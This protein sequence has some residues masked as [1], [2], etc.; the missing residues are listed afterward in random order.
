MTFSLYSLKLNTQALLEVLMIKVAHLNKNYG[1]IEA[2]KDFSLVINAREKLALLGPNGAGK[3]TVM[4]MLATLIRPSS[5]KITI[6]G[7]DVEKNSDAVR[8]LIGFLP[9]NPPIYPELRVREFLSFVAG[10]RSIS[11]KEEKQ[12]IDEVITNCNLESVYNRICGELSKGY[13][14]RLGIAQAIIHKPEILI[15]DEPTNGLDPTQM[16]EMKIMLEKVAANSIV[17]LSTHLMNVAQEFCS[18]VAILSAG[19]L[20]TLGSVEDLTK[21]QTLEEQ[22]LKVVNQ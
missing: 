1:Q 16:H 15:L 17:I 3:S 8:K 12:S 22:Y 7:L 5:G 4:R 20:V 11:K 13:R 21:R 2:V 9:E 14:Q 18:K 10:L 19:K 6:G